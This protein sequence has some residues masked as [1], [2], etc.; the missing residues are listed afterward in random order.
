VKTP[1]CVRLCVFGEWT[2]TVLVGQLWPTNSRGA[3]RWSP[4]ALRSYPA[5]CFP[6]LKLPEKLAGPWFL[7]TGRFDFLKILAKTSFI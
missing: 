1:V 6:S 2:Q 7:T 5:A 3:M 4:P